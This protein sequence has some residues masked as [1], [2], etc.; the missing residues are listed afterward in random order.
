MAVL[1][2]TK[3]VAQAVRWQFNVVIGNDRIFIDVAFK[4]ATFDEAF[5]EVTLGA[6]FIGVYGF[7]VGHIH[8]V[9]V[10]NLAGL[11]IAL[12]YRANLH[13]GT[14]K[15][16][17][18]RVPEQNHTRDGVVDL[19]MDQVIWD[20]KGVKRTL[21]HLIEIQIVLLFRV[22]VFGQAIDLCERSSNDVVN[23]SPQA[24]QLLNVV[25]LADFHDV[26]FVFG[27]TRHAPRFHDKTSC[28][29]D[30]GLFEADL[31]AVGK[32]GDHGRVLPPFFRE[33]FLGG[34]I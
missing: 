11:K 5:R 29:S 22:S 9:I 10:E 6:H 12:S 24:A 28:V 23:D 2:G 1:L 18:H 4:L 21:A 30:D 19:K 26:I 14:A 34:R 13:D 7:P 27:A 16:L 17:G 31:R 20:E 33:A 15:W 25:E 3:T 8:T 32:A